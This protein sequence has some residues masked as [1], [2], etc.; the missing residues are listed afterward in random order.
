VGSFE[1]KVSARCMCV[2]TIFDLQLSFFNFIFVVVIR[3]PISSYTVD[4][5]SRINNDGSTAK[6]Q[7]C[8]P[9]LFHSLAW[10]CSGQTLAAGLG[11]GSI[12]IFAIEN[13]N[14]VETG[15]ITDGAHD[16]AVVSLTFPIFSV[17]S[18]E[19]ILCSAGSDGSIFFWD[20]GSVICLGW[21]DT[22][23]G[24]AEG[25]GKGSNSNKS[26][27]SDANITDLF[28]KS[29]SLDNQ[30]N[31]KVIGKPTKLFGI[32]HGQ[33]MNW[34]TQAATSGSSKKDVIF[35]ADT[36]PDITCYTIPMR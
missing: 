13:R 18:A 36:S 7:V 33:K 22:E 27:T 10:S 20:L 5:Q 21:G 12:G 30:G 9:P 16:S 11:N 35:V 6:P 2:T 31:G 4:H 1:A 17:D 23:W 3:K 32:P 24:A 28:A 26:S 34:V 25:G 8:N 15:R 14:L 29:V 19:R